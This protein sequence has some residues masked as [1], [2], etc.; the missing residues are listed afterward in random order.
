MLSDHQFIEQIKLK[1]KSGIKKKYLNLDELTKLISSYNF[2]FLEN[3][4]SISQKFHKIEDFD[5]LIL[6]GEIFEII[7]KHLKT[8]QNANGS[9]EGLVFNNENAKI[10]IDAIIDIFVFEKLCFECKSGGLLEK[11]NPFDETKT[12]YFCRKCRRN[13]RIFQN[14]Q[15]LPIFLLYLKKWMSQDKESIFINNPNDNSDYNEEFI[16]YLLLDCFNYYKDKGFIKA[17]LLFYEIIVQNKKDYDVIVNDQEFQTILIKN[18]KAALKRQDFYGFIKGKE[19]YTSKYGVLPEDLQGSIM[20]AIINSLKTGE[21]LKIKYA[22]DHLIKEEFSTLLKDFSNKGNKDRIEKNFYLGLLNCLKS[23]KFENFKQ[24][25]DLSVF[26]DIFINV[27]KIP[28]RIEIISSIIMDCIKEVTTGYQTSSLGKQI[29]ILR[30]CNQFNLFELNEYL[31]EDLRIIREI[32]QDKLLLA[33]LN[34]LFGSITDAFVLYIKKIIPQMLFEFFIKEP[35]IFYTNTDQLAYYIKNIFFNQYSIYGLSVKYLSSTEHFIKEFN[36][37]YLLYQKQT[38]LYENYD[39]FIEFKVLYKYQLYYFDFE[40]E[41]EQF[42]LKKHLVSPENILNNISN[43]LAKDNYK[44]YSLS[45]VLLGGLGPQGHG[46]TYSTPKGEVVEI[47][48]DIRENE[49]III[50]YREFLKQQFIRKLKKELNKSKI[51]S[52]ISEKIINYL[53]GVLNQNELIN[54]YKKE[55]ILRQI[56]QFLNEQEHKKNISINLQNFIEKISNAINSILREVKMVDQFKTR[57]DLVSQDKIKSEDVAKL[58]SLRD[59]SH[60]DV[61]RERF[62]FQ[63]IVDWFYETYESKREE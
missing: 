34:D 10:F 36:K 22:I 53:Q 16:F 17:I 31:E 59:K 51:D 30:F 18:L 20:D 37:N 52:N 60:Y 39:K 11:K 21:I 29:D 55:G 35:S 6:Y 2:T 45:M 62:F 27:K 61:L 46:F 5:T 14:T 48:S 13:V 38:T 32:K 33:N 4:Q 28:D 12:L 47:C 24:M 56:K 57:M 40:E 1:I 63:Y 58:T 42:I 15:H 23:K 26:F 50:K 19:F 25:F 41:R 3:F 8:L 43:I 44:F 54:F 9:L 7:L 49:A